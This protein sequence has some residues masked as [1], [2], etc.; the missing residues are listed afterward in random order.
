MSRHHRRSAGCNRASVVTASALWFGREGSLGQGS[1]TVQGH[2]YMVSGWVVRE[3]RIRDCGI[4]RDW[5]W[6]C[7]DGLACCLSWR[8]AD[9]GKFHGIEAGGQMGRR[10]EGFKE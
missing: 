6:W 8:H 9:V 3:R 4:L 5:G 1:K 7:V 10:F 2:R